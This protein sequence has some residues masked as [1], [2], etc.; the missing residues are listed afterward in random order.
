MITMMMMMMKENGPVVWFSV[1]VG[2]IGKS[3]AKINTSN[4]FKQTEKANKHGNKQQS[5]QFSV[6]TDN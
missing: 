1:S 6:N 4:R 3:Q 5:C 2:L